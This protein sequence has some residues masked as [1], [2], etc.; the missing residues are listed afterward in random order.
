MS[1]S[2]TFLRNNS[3]TTGKSENTMQGTVY[4]KNLEHYLVHRDGKVISCTLSSRLRKEFDYPT[5]SEQSLRRVVKKVKE[6][7][8]VDPIAIGDRVHLIET[9]AGSGMIVEVLP[10]RNRLSRKTAVPMPGAHAFEQVIVANID[11]VIPVFAAADP[12]PRWNMLDRYLVAAESLGL[13][14]QICITKLDLVQS[15]D[16]RVND[17]LMAEV[18]EYRRIGYRVILLSAHTG[19][20]L[21]ELKQSLSGRTSVFVGKSGVGKSSLLNVL[22][23]GLGL[24]VK[25]V[26][27]LTGKGRHTTSHL[28]MFPLEFDEENEKGAI[29]DTPGTREFGLWDI[30]E[31]DL[32]LFFP[33]MKPY[34]GQCRFGLDCQHDEEPGCAIRKAVT[35]GNISPRRYQSFLRLKED[36]E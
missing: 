2:N 5:A 1:L 6:I 24:K 29:V 26:S 10:R 7:E 14:T 27:R 20:G 19:Q 9:Q 21:A 25:E 15:Q 34:V 8:H 4:K 13:P 23:P 32:A 3:P 12:A 11:Q 16:G 28:E 36:C 31:D 33:E 35:G 18:Q 22:Q 30:A 17:D